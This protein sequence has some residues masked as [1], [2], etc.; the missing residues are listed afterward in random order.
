MSIK[1]LSAAILVTPFAGCAILAGIRPPLAIYP[2]ARLSDCSI[3]GF[4]ACL[5]ARLLAFSPIRLFAY[6]LIRMPPPTPLG[7]AISDTAYCRSR[8]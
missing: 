2:L 6:T 5:I 1:E 8:L 7:S 4:F 3:V